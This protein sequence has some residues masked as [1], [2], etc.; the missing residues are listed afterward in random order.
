M[1]SKKM[2]TRANERK[3]EEIKGNERKTRQFEKYKN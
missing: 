3:Q 2:K 1:S